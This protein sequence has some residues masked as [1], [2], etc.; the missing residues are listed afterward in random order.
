[1][2]MSCFRGEGRNIKVGYMGGDHDGAIRVAD[3]NRGIRDM[4]V[5]EWCG[6]REEMGHAAS[7]GDGCEGGRTYH[8]R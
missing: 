2:N 8:C 6:Y 7:V 1:M 5:G 4:F 3:G